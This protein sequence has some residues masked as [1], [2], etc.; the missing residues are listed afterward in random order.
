MK[1]HHVALTVKDLEQSVG[2]YTS[3]FNLSV[4]FRFE[5]LD[6]G[7]AAV[8]LSTGNS[9]LELWAF[10][11]K[12]IGELTDLGVTGIK[13]VAFQSEDIESDYARLVKNGL[14]CQQV[15]EGKSGGKYFF[16]HDLDGNQIE[17]YQ[18]P[19]LQV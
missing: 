2:F 18:N 19:M 17:I 4:A 16:T 8:F 3:N 11:D 9:Y 14:K 10:N 13:H 6:M 12:K 7:A 15:K 5:R 1:L